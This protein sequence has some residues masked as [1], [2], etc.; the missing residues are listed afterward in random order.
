[1]R[2]RESSSKVP[3]T[4]FN[5]LYVCE[6]PLAS[7]SAWI[8]VYATDAFVNSVVY[9]LNHAAVT[10]HRLARLYKRPASTYVDLYNEISPAWRCI[11]RDRTSSVM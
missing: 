10:E 4:N 3:T 2:R 11:K 6:A 5:I 1:M 9:I 7:T 8:P